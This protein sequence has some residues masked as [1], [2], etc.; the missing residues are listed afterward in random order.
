MS[1]K[2]ENAAFRALLLYA[3]SAR[4]MTVKVALFPSM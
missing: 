3:E 2:V 4:I 1:S